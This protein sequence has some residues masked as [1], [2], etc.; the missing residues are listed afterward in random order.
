MPVYEDFRR[1]NQ[2]VTAMEGQVRLNFTNTTKICI[3]TFSDSI[4]WLKIDILWKK[5][6]SYAAKNCFGG[7][8]YFAN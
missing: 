5:I 8:I 2:I 7:P 6:L 4:I 3:Y 1:I